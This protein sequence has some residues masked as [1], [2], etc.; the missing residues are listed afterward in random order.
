MSAAR[1]SVCIARGRL[2]YSEGLRE[3]IVAASEPPSLRRLS[4]SQL[5]SSNG[6]FL[7]LNR[8]E[9]TR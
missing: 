2:G 4:M 3:G 1:V 5:E 8:K 7:P 9:P 6:I